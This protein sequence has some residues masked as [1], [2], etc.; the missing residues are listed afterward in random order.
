MGFNT[1]GINGSRG[2]IVMRDETR[3]RL[4]VVESNIKRIED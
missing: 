1:E 2:D 4:S 3:V